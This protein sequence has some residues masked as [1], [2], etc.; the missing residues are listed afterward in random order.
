MSVWLSACRP[1]KVRVTDTYRNLENF[2][3]FIA[4]LDGVLRVHSRAGAPPASITIPRFF[5]I[6]VG[7]TNP[8]RTAFIMEV[9]NPDIIISPTW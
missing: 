1:D 8:T 7:L 5:K 3:L 6:L 2:H 4:S 9:M